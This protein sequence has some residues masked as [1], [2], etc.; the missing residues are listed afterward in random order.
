MTLTVTLA[1]VGAAAADSV[2]SLAA[3]RWQLPRGFPEPLVP[4]DNPMS[5]AKVALGRRLFFETRLSLTA[6][7][8]CASCHD[9]AHAFTDGRAKAVGAT[10]QSTERSAM[11]LVNVA[12]NSSYGW[13]EP[14]VT[15]LEAQMYQPLFN[16]HPIEMGLA[17]REAAMVAGL[18]A[19]AGYVDAFNAAFPEQPT[20]IS[21]ANLIRAIACYERTLISGNSPF[22]RYV[23]GGQHDAIDA[24]AKRGMELFY[25]ARLGCANCHAGFNFTGTVVYRDQ[26]TAVPAFARNG[27]TAAPI[28]VPTLRN[29]ALTA[30]YMH[31]GRFAT[32]DE[33]IA[34]Y[35]SVGASAEA[36]EKL[37]EFKLTPDE[38]RAL[39]AFLESLT[40]S[41]F[42]RS[43]TQ[44]NDSR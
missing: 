14:T 37:R 3:Y 18:S 34:H 36:D 26:A 23:F 13:T 1:T 27:A 32:L 29:I 44:R 19:D 42:I 38:R 22:D 41:E 35:E 4:A 7:Y 43:N 15:T 12:Y 25:S 28:R 8:S 17:G 16:E 9:P 6:T 30:P 10:G 2:H 5:P 24:M 31:D 21:I 20:G 33:V 11:T 40:D 39:R